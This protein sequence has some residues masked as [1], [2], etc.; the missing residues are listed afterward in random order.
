[1]VYQ[2]TPFGL[3]LCTRFMSQHLLSLLYK[4]NSSINDDKTFVLIF[5]F[6]ISNPH[7]FTSFSWVRELSVDLT[8]QSS[9]L[10]TY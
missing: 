9:Q 5:L 1:V 2:A 4:Y 6:F 3:I 7:G 10:P 8:R